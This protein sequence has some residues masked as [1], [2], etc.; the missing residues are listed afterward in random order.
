M[1]PPNM[2][3]FVTHEPNFKDVSRHDSDIICLALL[4]YAPTC[5]FTF[6]SWLVTLMILVYCY[7]LKSNS[8]Q[9][10]LF[11]NTR[12]TAHGSTMRFSL[13]VHIHVH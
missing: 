13:T 3:H 6:R 7:Q 9:L 8:G 2:K 4:F 5:R 12:V 1:I 10:K 11:A